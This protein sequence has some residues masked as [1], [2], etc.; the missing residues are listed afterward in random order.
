MDSVFH[1]EGYLKHNEARQNHLASLNIPISGKTV[2]EVGAGIGDHT[3]FFLERSCEVIVT[4]GRAEN[5]ERLKKRFPCNDV[6]LLDVDQELD[7]PLPTVDI[8]YCYGLLYHLR[9]PFGA[10]NRL[11]TECDE[12]F[13]LETCVSK[14]DK[15]VLFDEGVSDPRNSVS[16]G[17]CR[18][19]RRD[20]QVALQ[21]NFAHVYFPLTQPNHDDFPED[22]NAIA[23]KPGLDR[24]VFIASRFELNNP[25]L[26]KTMPMK[27]AR[28]K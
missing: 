8:V 12:M 22:W 28:L 9:D 21:K 27:Q 25:L 4:D 6:Y 14:D 15:T 2:L 7:E 1:E 20:V 24:A 3:R 19:S 10:I 23:G 13:L 26:T 17:A 18:P 11:S 16:G 5:V